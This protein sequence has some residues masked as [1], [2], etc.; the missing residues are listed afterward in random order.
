MNQ[1]PF[2][3]G[4]NALT[5]EPLLHTTERVKM[6]KENSEKRITEDFFYH[7]VRMEYLRGSKPRVSLLLQ[8]PRK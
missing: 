1:Q 3:N 6:W 2:N 4:A 5:I 8:L 7:E